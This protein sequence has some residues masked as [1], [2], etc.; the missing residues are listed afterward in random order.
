MP[1]VLP[2][3]SCVQITGV[4]LTACRGD[5]WRDTVQNIPM[6]LLCQTCGGTDAARHVAN[7]LPRRL[8]CLRADAPAPHPRPQG[9]TRHHA[10]PDGGTRRS[11]PG[12]SRRPYGTHL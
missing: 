1:A 6:I 5:S 10:V 12:V 7:D 4:G 9:R 3:A 8:S 2:P 11:C